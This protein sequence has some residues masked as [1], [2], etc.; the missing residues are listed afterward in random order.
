MFSTRSIAFVCAS[1]A[2][3]VTVN[4]VPT[5]ATAAVT[6][7]N[8]VSTLVACTSP[9]VQTSSVVQ[10]VETGAIHGCDAYDYVF[11]C[12][13]VGFVNGACTH[14]SRNLINDVGSVKV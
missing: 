1:M 10:D 4:A 2:T 14:L 7:P 6:G 9:S 12:Q 3:L 13:N 8:P 5:N 11:G